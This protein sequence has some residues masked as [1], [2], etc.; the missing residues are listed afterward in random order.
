MVPAEKRK[1]FLLI[2]DAWANIRKSFEMNI[3][4]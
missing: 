2:S 4:L 1:D 3:V